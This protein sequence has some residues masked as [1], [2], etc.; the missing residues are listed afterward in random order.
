MKKF[1]SFLAFCLLLAIA[2]LGTACGGESELNTPQGFEID[3]E[4]I[5]SWVEVENARQYD[6]EIVNVQSAETTTGVTRR[7][8]YSLSELQEGDYDIRVRAIGGSRNALQSDWSEPV[9][10]HKD[11]ESGLVYTLINQNS[12]YAV[13][14]VGSAEGVVTIEEI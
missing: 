3:D 13:T 6:V 10:F 11:F 1:R 9:R 4:N 8:N 2:L 5:L 7:N 12:E 14:R